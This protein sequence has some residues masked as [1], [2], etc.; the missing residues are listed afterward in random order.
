[1]YKYYSDTW[2]LI[3]DCSRGLCSPIYLAIITILSGKSVLANQYDETKE[4]YCIL[5]TWDSILFAWLPTSLHSCLVTPPILTE[6][7]R[8]IESTN[9]SPASFGSQRRKR[10]LEENIGNPSMFANELATRCYFCDPWLLFV[11]LFV[12]CKLSFLRVACLTHWF[13]CKMM[14]P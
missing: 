2:W 13:V 1:M 10:S 7:L 6:Y 5:G 4:D 8:C 3:H 11:T 12:G 14:A 9:L